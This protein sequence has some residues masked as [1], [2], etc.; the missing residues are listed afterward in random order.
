MNFKNKVVFVSGA[1]RGIGAAIAKDFAQ[2]GAIVIGTATSEAGTKRITGTL[3]QY[4]K[5][6]GIKLNI[7]ESSDI[8]T[9]FSWM[10]NNTGYPDI[11]INNA[12]ITKDNL[13]VRLT[14]D[15]W[16]K[17]IHT[18]LDSV[19]KISKA[20]VRHMMKKLWGRIITIG[21]VVGTSGNPGQSNYCAS[22]AGVIGFSKSL[23]REIASRNITVNVVAPGFIKTDMTEKLSHEQ[24]QTITNQIPAKKLGEVE[25][26]AAIVTFLASDS[27]RYI[28][29]QTIH[30]NG[31]IYMA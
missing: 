13:M 14:E 3:Q 2:G 20:G 1:S 29:G 18:N 26:I 24:K 30:V 17:V 25:D 9:A 28:T 11:I 15:D 22:K 4:G 19:F 16:L 21:S 6:H 31:G 5:G 12:G 7:S 27:A 10:Q 23:A 8:E